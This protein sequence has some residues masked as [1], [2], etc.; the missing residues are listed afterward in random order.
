MFLYGELI[1]MT[2]ILIK[3][4]GR[5]GGEGREKMLWKVLNSD[6]EFMTMASSD[7]WSSLANLIKS[8]TS[9]NSLTLES[10]KMQLDSSF[11][12]YCYFSVTHPSSLLENGS[13]LPLRFPISNPEVWTDNAGEEGCLLSTSFHHQCHWLSF[14]FS[15]WKVSSRHPHFMR[16]LSQMLPTRQMKQSCLSWWRTWLTFQALFKK[17]LAI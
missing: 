4:R 8:K 12:L 17:G 16:L 9:R 13:S 3:R 14:C 7:F 15:Q 11:I 1:N 10:W 2:T 6:R 5:V